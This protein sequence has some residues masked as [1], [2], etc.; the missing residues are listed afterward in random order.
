MV[1]KG[2][3]LHNTLIFYT[4]VCRARKKNYQPLIG[5][6]KKTGSAEPFKKN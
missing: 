3:Y 2:Y 1:S 4:L 5:L 6:C